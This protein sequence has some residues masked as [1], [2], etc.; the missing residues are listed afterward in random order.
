MT[1][2]S[3][4]YVHDVPR[5]RLAREGDLDL[6]KETVRPLRFPPPSEWVARVPGEDPTVLKEAFDALRAINE[7]IVDFQDQPPWMLPLFLAEAMR[8]WTASKSEEPFG[9]WVRQ[10]VAEP[11]RTMLQFHLL[12]RTLRHPDNIVARCAYLERSSSSEVPLRAAGVSWRAAACQE[13]QQHHGLDVLFQV[14]DRLTTDFVAMQARTMTLTVLG[15]TNDHGYV[16]AGEKTYAETF[17]KAVHRI[18]EASPE[19]RDPNATYWAILPCE[20]VAA[21]AL[22][23][24]LR[25]KRLRDAF[26]DVDDRS[27]GTPHIVG[28]LGPIARVDAPPLRLLCIE[29]PNLPQTTGLIGRASDSPEFA[30]ITATVGPYIAAFPREE[31]RVVGYD[32]GLNII[33]HPKRLVRLALPKLA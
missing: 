28:V 4:K 18:E 6:L 20:H 21:L 15:V 9:I 31:G 29:E 2:L 11:E 24:E 10:A 1:D 5:V 22:G 16:V 17:S 25:S 8:L 27:V 7:D 14:L 12:F 19:A 33:A 32:R 26:S 30:S 13:L 3:A 23:T